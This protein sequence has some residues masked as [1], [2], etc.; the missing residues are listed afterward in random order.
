MTGDGAPVLGGRAPLAVADRRRLLIRR[1]A[2]DPPH[3]EAASV[4]AAPP[5]PRGSRRV[6]VSTQATASQGWP[7]ACSSGKAVRP[8]RSTPSACRSRAG[9]NA[10]TVR[11]GAGR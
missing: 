8:T 2:G 4:A 1:Q 6:L 5:L 7:S 9:R 11:R 3:R 10:F